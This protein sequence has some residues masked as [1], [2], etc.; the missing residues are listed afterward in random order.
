MSNV[1]IQKSKVKI[2]FMGIPEFGAIIL[3]GLINGGSKPILVVTAPD[4]PVGRK[5]ILTPPPVKLLAER[6]KIPILQPKEIRNSKFEIRKLE[7]DLI[8]VAA[9]GQIL[10]KEILE[11]PK[12]GCLNIHPSLL[13]RWRGPS[14]IRYTILNGD[15]TTGVTIILMNE[16][17]DHGPILTNFKIKITD[18]KITYLKLHNKLAELGA[19]LLLETIPKWIKGEIK[20]KPQDESKATYTKIL[21]R[22]DG[23]IDWRKSAEDLEKQIRA[24][25]IWPGSFSFWQKTRNKIQRIKILK[26]K[27]LKKII[28]KTYP[29]GKT[30]LTPKNELCVQTGKGFLIIEKLQLEGKKEIFCEEFLRGHSDFIGTILK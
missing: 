17:M 16:K 18:P 8:V 3:E 21:T 4:K 24:F 14:P 6:Y 30:L 10:P 9:Y 27:V 22:E 20:P 7:P 28:T 5:Q 12:F 19:K 11:I 15:K 26:A 23:K 29:I 1:N 25:E 2:I 13:P